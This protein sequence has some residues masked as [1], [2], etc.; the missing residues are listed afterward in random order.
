MPLGGAIC[1]LFF[2]EFVYK[3]TQTVIKHNRE[4]EKKEKHFDHNDDKQDSLLHGNP[5]SEEPVHL[6]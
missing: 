1:A 3:K 6:A 4:D 2:F 5:D